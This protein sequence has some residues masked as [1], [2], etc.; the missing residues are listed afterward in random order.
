MKDAAE[1]ILGKKEKELGTDDRQG[2]RP[3]RQKKRTE[4]KQTQRQGGC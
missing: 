3:L 2:P 1:E 4:T